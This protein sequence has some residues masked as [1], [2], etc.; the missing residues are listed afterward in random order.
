MALALYRK[1]RPRT[2]AEVIGQEHVTEPLSQALRSGRLNHAY[3]FSGPRG[4]GKTSSARILARSLNCE[5]GPTPEPCGTCD[6]CRSL[7]G[8]GAGSIDVIEID[9]ASHGGVDDAR[10]LREK[11]FFAPANSRFK[12]YVIDEAHMVSSAGFNALLKLVEEPPEYVKFIFATTE[13]EKVL[14]TIKSRT[15]HYPFRLIP[16][17]VLRPYLE[18]L[19]QAE[20]VPVEPAVFP[21]VVRA[22]GG[23]A[24][25]SLSVLDQLIA[26]AGPDGVSYARAAA[27]LGVTDAALIDEMCDALAAGDGA[28]A[29]ATVDRVA[30]AGHD[31]RRFAA[32][33]LERL[34]DLIV[35]QQVPDAVT[36]GL[37]DGPDDQI[38]RM[39]AQAQQLGPG[40]LSRCA[41]IVHDGLVEMR[42]T[43]APRLLL[44]LICARMLLPGVDDGTGGLLQR[45]ERMER[46][47]TLAGTDAPPATAGSAPATNPPTVRTQPPAAPAAAAANRAGTGAAAPATATSSSA[48]PPPGR[49]NAS[50]SAD[51]G[52]GH[53]SGHDASAGPDGT[54]QDAGRDRVTSTAGAGTGGTTAGE[55]A[56]AGRHAGMN[57]TADGPAVGPSDGHPGWSGGTQDGA[58]NGRATPRRPVPQSAVMPDPA[59]PE[60]PRPGAVSPGVLDAVAVRRVWPEVVGKVNRSNKRI[61]ALMRDAVVR[62]LDG[63]TLVLTVKSAV[64]ARMMSDHAQV[65][66]D[67]LYEELGGRWQIRCEVAG[68]AGAAAPAPRPTP[69]QAAVPSSPAPAEDRGIRRPPSAAGR[70]GHSGDTAASEEEDWP[71]PARPGGSAPSTGI[72]K[73][74]GQENSGAGGTGASQ[75]DW[76]KT[77]PLGGAASAGPPR[78]ATA[79]DAGPL[80]PGQSAGPSGGQ[81]AAAASAGRMPSAPPQPSTPATRGSGAAPAS[82]ALAAARAAAAGR[83]SR[84]AATWQAADADWAG[85]PPYDPDYDGPVTGGKIRPSAAPTYEGF[86]PGDEPLDEVLDERTAR[87]SSEE[88]AVRLFKEAFGGAEKIDETNAR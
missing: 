72:A 68:Q 54:T 57:G 83:G 82:N 48:A 4:C 61:A 88:Q 80:P 58:T 29:Y 25:D 65:L 87:E 81:S 23:S 41:D 32:D 19:T 86:D 60:P 43:T 20:G 8:D 38:E 18:Q 69:A 28:A 9:A 49:G 10:E 73:G 63:D 6:S 27:L 36:K 3:L 75:G 47:L 74:T 67:A 45:L 17:K 12:I 59:T 62:D 5:H 44:E 51:R 71:E 2:F 16:P 7:A 13:P 11:A 52:N 55:G 66:T 53:S 30:E 31:P 79:P 77:A 78:S 70:T 33:L 15:H 34:R 1:Y 21:L 56:D 35:L 85:E 14:G 84:A 39:A 76:P 46:R 22:G 24:R 37:I 26:G 42:G 64:L 50:S 40:T